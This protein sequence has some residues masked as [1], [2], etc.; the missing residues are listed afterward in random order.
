MMPS[1]GRG[2]VDLLVLVRRYQ[3][4][5]WNRLL[6][7]RLRVGLDNIPCSESPEIG[8]ILRDLGDRSQTA[9]STGLMQRRGAVICPIDY[10]VSNNSQ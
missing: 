9:V 10:S 8:E 3:R 7:D 1:H 6:E 2:L 4:G 5:L